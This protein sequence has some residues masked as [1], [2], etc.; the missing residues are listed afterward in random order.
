MIE[1]QI[2]GDGLKEQLLELIQIREGLTFNRKYSTH[3]GEVHFFIGESYACRTESALTST[4]ILEFKYRTEAYC[5]IISSGGGAGLCNIDWGAQESNEK[6][7]VRN[8]ERLAEE[9]DW[10][11]KYFS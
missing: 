6:S 4:V 1:L 9:N 3:D 5:T 7:I 8:I 2:F 10:V 11:I